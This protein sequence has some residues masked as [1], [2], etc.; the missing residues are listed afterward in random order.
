[1]LDA[2][3]RDLVARA[4]PAGAQAQEGDERGR[5]HD[6]CHRQEHRLRS[7]R[8]VQPDEMRNRAH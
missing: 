8:K 2:A 3:G 7:V 5:P 6:A 4:L 1:M